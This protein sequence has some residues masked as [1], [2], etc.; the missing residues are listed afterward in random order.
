MVLLFWVL[1]FVI[2]WVNA[3]GCGKTWNE[4]KRNGGVPHFLNWMGAIMSASGFTWCYLVIGI[5]L[6]TVIPY[7]HADGTWAPLLKPETSEAVA[8]LGYLIVIFPIL[9]SGLA[10]MMH[11]WGVFWRRRTFGNGA[12]AGYNTFAEAYNLYSAAQYVPKAAGKTEGFFSSSSDKDRGI[13]LLLVI[14]SVFGGILTTRAILLASARA[15]AKD[16]AFEAT[17]KAS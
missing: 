2:S 14:A 10:I 13:V 3:W 12:V 7:H 17:A 1:N 9:G 15:T 5:F 6:G 8:N 11:S 4:T 16:R